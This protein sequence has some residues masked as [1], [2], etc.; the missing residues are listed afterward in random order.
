MLV[1]YYLTSTHQTPP[2]VTEHSTCASLLLVLLAISVI[3]QPCVSRSVLTTSRPHCLRI[4]Q[5][6]MLARGDTVTYLLRNTK[7]L[8][9]DEA[10]RP[11][12]QSGL[13]ILI[14]G[15][16]TSQ[17]DVQNAW[18][19]ASKDGP[20][21]FIMF[22]IGECVASSLSISNLEFSIQANQIPNSTRSRAS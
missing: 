5:T 14:K 2:S 13:A 11:F 3:M 8:E 15:D 9:D 6:V 21:D 4:T 20:V 12:I 10:V 22:T 17:P 19:A 16:A 18:A 7:P 1:S